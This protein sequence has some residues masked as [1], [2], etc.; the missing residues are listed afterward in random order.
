MYV[1]VTDEGNGNALYYFEN[2]TTGKAE[3]FG[4]A[5]THVD[6]STA[7]FILERILGYYLPNFGQT[8]VVDNT[9]EQVSTWHSL[10][11]GKNDLYTMTSN[12]NS[13]GTVLAQPGAISDAQ[14]TQNTYK[15]SPFCDG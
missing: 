1:E 2:V 13:S 5:A 15:S 9:F 10:V 4:N 11:G 12:C 14:F 3:S 8:L 6:D 7:D